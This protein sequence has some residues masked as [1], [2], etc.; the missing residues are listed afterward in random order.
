M[1]LKKLAFVDGF[2]GVDASLSLASPVVTPPAFAPDA[3]ILLLPPP[4]ATS[5]M[6]RTTAA[7]AAPLRAFAFHGVLTFNIV[8]PPINALR[9]AT[10]MTQCVHQPQSKTCRGLHPDRH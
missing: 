2:D 8:L 6:S 5:D 10:R 7:A 9:D 4:Q 3:V 1:R